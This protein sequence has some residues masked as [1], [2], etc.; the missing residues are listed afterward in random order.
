MHGLLIL[1]ALFEECR[2]HNPPPFPF[3]RGGGSSKKCLVNR[4]SQKRRKFCLFHRKGSDG[5]GGKEKEEFRR[6]E[7]SPIN[8]LPLMSFI[9]PSFFYPDISGGIGNVPTASRHPR[10]RGDSP[11]HLL[12]PVANA[13]A[14]HFCWPVVVPLAWLLGFVGC[15][16]GCCPSQTNLPFCIK[17]E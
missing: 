9:C 16:V 11:F 4:V 10:G 7:G 1:S 6:N 13:A 14:G 3:L 2:P 12:N 8:T 5:G 17:Y 15:V